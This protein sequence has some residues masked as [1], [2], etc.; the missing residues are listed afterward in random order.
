MQDV[1]SGCFFFKLS[2]KKHSIRVPVCLQTLKRAW[3]HNYTI[4]LLAYSAYGCSESHNLLKRSIINSCFSIIEIPFRQLFKLCAG[5][6]VQIYQE[7][8]PF[9]AFSYPRCTRWTWWSGSWTVSSSVET[10]VNLKFMTTT[11]TGKWTWQ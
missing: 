9:N 5:F 1:F 2:T 10:F 7:A 11:R 6:F 8:M 4:L 3:Y